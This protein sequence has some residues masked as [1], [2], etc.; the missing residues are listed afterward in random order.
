MLSC[1]RCDVCVDLPM[2]F[3]PRMCQAS[4][5][6]R[7]IAPVSA[8]RFPPVQDGHTL[9]VDNQKKKADRYITAWVVR[10]GISK[11]SGIPKMDGL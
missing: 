7:L 3:F 5:S 8:N 6:V 4:L 11:N 10:L 2:I 9:A 1:L